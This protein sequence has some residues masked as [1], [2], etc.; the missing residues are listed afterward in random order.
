MGALI[1][2]GGSKHMSVFVFINVDVYTGGQTLKFN[3]YCGDM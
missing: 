3:L 1:F 2:H